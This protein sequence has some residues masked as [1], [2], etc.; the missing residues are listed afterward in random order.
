MESRPDRVATARRIVRTNPFYDQ[1]Y[2]LLLDVSQSV[3]FQRLGLY[4]LRRQRCLFRTRA[5]H[6]RGS[7]QEFARSFSNRLDSHQTSLGRYVVVATYRGRYGRAYR[8]AG[9]EA[10]NDHA[11]ARGIV[12]CSSVYVRPGRLVRSEGCPAVS[13]AALRT[14]RPYLRE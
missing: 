14:L 6:G 5:L 4:D 9:L 8:L 10:S 11:L 2:A 1:K 3:A 12:L 7:D 13:E